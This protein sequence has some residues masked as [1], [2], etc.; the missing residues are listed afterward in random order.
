MSEGAPVW[1]RAPSAEGRAHLLVSKGPGAVLDVV[2]LA[3]ACTSFGRNSVTCDVAL[4]HPSL[5]RRHALIAY[6]GQ[7]TLCVVDL[8]STHGTFLNAERIP[9]NQPLTLEF[10]DSLTFGASSRVYTVALGPGEAPAAEAE[11]GGRGGAGEHLSMPPP[12]PPP[13]STHAEAKAAPVLVVVD[14]GS[15]ERVPQPSSAAADRLALAAAIESMSK[16]VAYRPEAAAR[17]S[18][19]EENGMV[20]GGGAK[21]TWGDQLPTSFGKQSGKR[22]RP[23][24]EGSGEED[25]SDEGYGPALPPRKPAGPSAAA[26][27]EAVAAAALTPAGQAK[28]LGLPTSHEAVLGGHSKTVTCVGFDA[29]GGRLVTGGADYA[30]RLYDFGGMD[31]SH[32]SFRDTV[33][34][35]GQPLRGVAW[36]HTGD[37]FA[38][39]T[40]SAQVRVFDREGRQSVATIKGDQYLSDAVNTKGHQSAATWVGWHPSPARKDT[41]LSAGADGTVRMWDLA[42]G[43]KIFEELTCSDVIKLKSAKGGKVAV[44]TAAVDPAGKFVLAGTDDG[45]IH[46]VL[47]KGPGYRYTRSDAT[48]RGAHAAGPDGVTSLVFTPD[49]SRFASRGADEVV[50]VWPAQALTDRTAPLLSF[51][52]VSSAAATANVAWSPDGRLLCAGVAVPTGRAAASA[53]AEAAGRVLVWDVP[54]LVTSRAGVAAGSAAEP[55]EGVPGDSV[56]VFRVAL[57]PRVSPVALEWQAKLNQIAVACSDGSTRLLYSPGLSTKGA[58]LSSM[59]APKPRDSAADSFAAAS[60]G[61]IYLPNALPLFKDDAG[62]MAGGGGK[63]GGGGAAISIDIKPS[64]GGAG[65]AKPRDLNAAVPGTVPDYLTKGKRT[66]TE[67]YMETV[68]DVPGYST[69]NLRAEDPV[70]RLTA[71]ATSAP[72]AAT[73]G[74]LFTRVYAGTQPTALL[75]SK[76]LEE[77]RDEAAAKVAAARA[78]VAGSLHHK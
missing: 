19:E 70:A 34:A 20:V 47:L 37:R 17:V 38:V 44:T 54:A 53:D 28:A 18:R 31:A 24:E 13:P 66:F 22:P 3:N 65:P 61:S 73:A 58:L 16:P 4:D 30:L 5:S 74:S 57:P 10:G 49:G 6:T 40:G 26:V 25:S 2:P 45:C 1:A 48:L 56:A 76:T 42:G 12:P 33:P 59:R 43:K 35:D 36:S 69:V 7:G 60:M 8:G 62:P 50:R 41:L 55:G 72:G 78:R 14:K 27:A 51:T 64:G 52:N 21:G 63:R 29:G 46:M 77:E 67:H 39:V 9:P 75:A 71:Y 68:G 32:K 15:A 23:E 11:G